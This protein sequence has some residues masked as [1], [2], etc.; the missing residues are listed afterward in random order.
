MLLLLLAQDRLV[1]VD[2]WQYFSFG[3]LSVLE[4]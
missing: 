1:S 3:L 2:A 4:I